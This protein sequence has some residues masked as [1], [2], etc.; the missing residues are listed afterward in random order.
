MLSLCLI[1][2]KSGITKKRGSMQGDIQMSNEVI[3]DVQENQ[4]NENIEQ[5]AETKPEDVLRENETLKEQLELMK[6]EK[7]GVDKS[8]SE[9]QK[10]LKNLESEKM[11]E[12]ER[13]EQQRREEQ[14]ALLSQAVELNAE[15]LNLDDEMKTLIAGSTVTEIKEK[16]KII[17][18]LKTKI[19]NEYKEKIA[20]LEQLVK[21]ESL[22]TSPPPKGSND[23]L[24]YK[25]KMPS[26][27]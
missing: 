26:F 24:D 20:E 3:E 21:K 13:I 17:T 1:L 6:R 5:Q 27:L 9:L 7:S 15:T 10:R 16:A 2:L 23:N 18:A 19:E 14:E 25:S 22:Q 4:N 8:V 12:Q 11:S